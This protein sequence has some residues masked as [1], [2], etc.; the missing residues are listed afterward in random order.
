MRRLARQPVPGFAAE[1]GCE[2]WAELALK[3]ILSNE[4]VTCVIPGTADP[5]HMKSNA[6]AGF[7]PL[8]DA[9]S[10]LKILRAAGL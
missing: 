8:P 4:A 1:L 7:G 3:Y 2:T 9:A 5:T 10:R 6:L